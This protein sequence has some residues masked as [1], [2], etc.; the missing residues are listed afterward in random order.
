MNKN[1]SLF[2][3]RQKNPQNLKATF[4]GKILQHKTAIIF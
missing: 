4:L 1:P 3:F 2:R